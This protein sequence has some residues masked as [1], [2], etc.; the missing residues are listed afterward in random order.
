MVEQLWVSC[1]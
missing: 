1:Q